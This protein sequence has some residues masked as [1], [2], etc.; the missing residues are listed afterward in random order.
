MHH[1][2]MGS[3]GLLITFEGPE[4]AGKSTQAGLLADHLN[5]LG[6]KCSVTRE[7]GG[8]PLAEQLRGIVKNYSG[9]E[10][11]RPETE[12][13]LIE[14][15]RVQHVHEFIL[16]RLAAGEVVICDR[17]TDSTVAYQGRARGISE[18]AVKRLNAFAVA[19]AVPRLTILLDMAPEA[20]FR[21]AETRPETQGEHDRFEEEKIGFHR[22][23]RSSFLATAA[24]EPGRVRVVNADRP[25]EE[26][27][28]EIAKI[29]E[30][31]LFKIS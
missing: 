12:L 3:G 5:Q 11:L 29:V 1:F 30:S 25:A 13:L 8:T 17:Y 2:D 15:A 28:R 6:V 7:P 16:P 14:A 18:D 10:K 4:G 20:G 23:V 19:G 9:S 21:R 24:A 26:I 22:A 27:H 31:A